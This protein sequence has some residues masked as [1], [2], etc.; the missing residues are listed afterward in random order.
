[1]TK[2]AVAISSLL[3]AAGLLARSAPVAAQWCAN[4]P[5]NPELTCFGAFSLSSNTTGMTNV[6]VGKLSL[7]SNLSGDGCTSVGYSAMWQNTSGT[8]NS[9]FGVG[10]LEIN[11]TGSYNVAVG[12]TALKYSDAD[13]GTAVGYQA[14]YANSRGAYNT[15]TGYESLFVN[16]TGGYNVGDGMDTLLS[17]T[18]GGYN[19]AVGPAALMYLVSGYYNVS[20]GLLAGASY[21]GGESNN[22]ALSNYGVAGD[23]GVIRIGSPFNQTKAFVA[24]I[25]G[26]TVASGIPVFVNSSGQ[27]GTATSS[28][29][30]KEEVADLGA[31]SDELMR[32]RPVSFRYKPAYDDGERVLQYGLIAEEVAAVDPGLVQNGADGLPLTVRYHFVNA[33][34]LGEVQRQHATIADQAARLERQATEVDDLKRQVASQ[35][36]GMAALAERLGTLEAAVSRH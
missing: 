25:Y 29:R 6:A 3:L 14:L 36:R 9:A 7:Y 33:M 8:L 35:D 31:A 30:F 13:G 34:L 12:A 17:N 15:A 32:L 11:S 5:S 28:L 26:S 18:T 24:G 4:N 2:R 1:M 16:G 27:V 21:T 23:M 10:A 22:I 20:M 19:V